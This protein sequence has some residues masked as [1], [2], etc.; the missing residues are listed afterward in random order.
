MTM[1]WLWDNKQREHGGASPRVSSVPVS[2]LI[3]VIQPDPADFGPVDRD[4]ADGE[5]MLPPEREMDKLNDVTRPSA[6]LSR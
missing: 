4:G 5:A 6:D 2:R 1:C 3:Q